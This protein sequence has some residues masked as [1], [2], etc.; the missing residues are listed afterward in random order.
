LEL[1]LVLVSF[2]CQP[3]S[4]SGQND[5][6]CGPPMVNKTLGGCPSGWVKLE[7]TCYFVNMYPYK[8]YAD[9]DNDCRD[10]FGLLMRI[11]SKV[12]FNAFSKLLDE[13]SYD[14]TEPFYTSGQLDPAVRFKFVWGGHSPDVAA[15]RTEIYD[16]W[17]DEIPREGD[18][19]PPESWGDRTFALLGNNGATWGFFLRNGTIPRPFICQAD[20][21]ALSAAIGSQR[22]FDYGV[23]GINNVRRSPCIQSE[24]AN[25]VYFEN[26]RAGSLATPPTAVFQCL[27]YGNPQPT[28]TWYRFGT[29]MQKT[30]IDPLTQTQYS[31][32]NG[33]LT[34]N[35]VESSR[36]SG[37]YACEAVNDLGAVMSRHAAL[38]F[39]ILPTFPKSSQETIERNA[40]QFA[41][42]E[43]KLSD[44]SNP[45]DLFNFQFFY[46]NIAPETS[47]DI[48]EV[49]PDF[50]SNLFV[51]QSTGRLYFS[52]VTSTDMGFYYCQ[53]GVTVGVS[54]QEKGPNIYLKV[55]NGGG[56]EISVMVA[57]GFPSNV[58]KSPLRGEDVQLECIGYGPIT[59]YNQ[60][61]IY[62]WRR[63]GLEIPSKSRW[64]DIF[65]RVLVIPNA[66][67]ED[68]GAY[69]CEI[70]DGNRRTSGYRRLQLT[71]NSGPYF[72]RRP[73]DLI[74]DEGTTQRFDCKASG[75]PPLTYAWFRGNNI[76][77]EL[78]DN[79]TDLDRARFT[80]DV[81]GSQ[82][83]LEIKNVKPSDSAAYG[84]RVTNS[85]ETIYGFAELRV[86]NFAPSFYKN[87]TSQESGLVGK[88]VY[89][90]CDVEGAPEPTRTW[91]FKGS[92]LA[93][94]K[95]MD[96]PDRKCPPTAKYCLLPSGK[97]QIQQLV[98]ADSGL[99]SCVAT[100][101]SGSANNSVS[102]AVAEQLT[103][104][105]APENRLVLVGSTVDLPC[106]L[107][108]TAANLDVNYMWKFENMEILFGRYDF[109]ARR[110]EL[111]QFY[112]P[113]KKDFGTLRISNIQYDYEG[114][115][116]CQ[117]QTPLG[118]E[119]RSAYL[120]VAG[121]PGPCAGVEV[122]S[123]N[124]TVFNIRWRSGTSHQSP[125]T[126]YQLELELA[127]NPGQWTVHSTVPMSEDIIVR[128]RSNEDT[129]LR[130]AQ[131]KGLPFY[132]Q[133][134]IR[135]SAINVYG[136]GLASPPSQVFVT[137][138][139][140]PS[141]A[142]QNITGG[143]GKVKTLV[144]RWKKI[145]L[146]YQ[147]GSN[148]TY[149]VQYRRVGDA[150]WLEASRIVGKP[151]HI[152]PDHVET[153][154]VLS[155][156][157]NE[158]SFKMFEARVRGASV[159][160]ETIN[161]V[162][163][164]TRLTGPWSDI[165]R[166]RSAEQVPVSAPINI[167]ITP[168]NA[169]AVDV[170]WEPPLNYDGIVGDILGYRIVYWPRIASACSVENN[171]YKVLLA[172]RQTTY[173]KATYGQVIGLEA[174]SFYCFSVQ[175]FNSAG[176]SPESSWRDVS[177][178]KMWPTDLP[179]N[180]V[181]HSTGEYSSISVTWN[182]VRQ[183]PNEESVD[184][185][186][187]R[188]W[189]TGAP[190]VNFTDV[191]AGLSNEVTVRYLSSETR[192]DLRVYA[193]S[194]GGIGTYS[195]PMIQFMLIP[196]DRCV[197]GASWEAPDVR[198]VFICSGAGLRA[199]LW[200]LALAGLARLLA[201]HY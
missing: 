123:I 29:N 88:S 184:G 14:K 93:V 166:L 151:M 64:G 112:R 53:V 111:T 40:F 1:L 137:V 108:A 140:P 16:F 173:G 26:T 85:Y 180:V 127:V 13:Q 74:V 161:N 9:A 3:L 61:L 132:Q 30:K 136:V 172:Q 189:V 47:S 2:L 42:I 46:S 72:V 197:P 12:E 52:E 199:S 89:L 103:F 109:D 44:N 133:Y 10:R 178:N 134:R 11:D 115:Y 142:P 168:F 162:E 191:D 90:P 32:T 195:S 4:I 56:D 157:T 149:D 129:G 147:G 23:V 84:C 91:R 125:I 82:P 158:I 68:S 27:A 6:Y 201:L 170:F 160:I 187:V 119:E 135:V 131:V 33:K 80:W 141:R 87:P 193:Y 24:P 31:V 152:P 7:S 183:Q 20:A 57:D 58:P 17:I 181:V 96:Q 106:Q 156:A 36:D 116:T 21:T 50:R 62:R 164:K 174:D 150:D 121:P 126:A 169:T 51:S 196:K 49:R 163:T 138:S 60:P 73:Y 39:G 107:K 5:Y 86:L 77:T 65:K 153:A 75:T 100:N 128:E 79:I 185:Y 95:V 67:M 167:R 179:T 78:L 143:G 19:K 175:L 155:G 192:Y 63:V 15:W 59:R 45:R 69:E 25:E 159:K 97:L 22:G 198:Y 105:F 114:N 83:Y 34:I 71:I 41:N 55:N 98:A 48:R 148:F 200:A 118:Y 8:T 70:E 120:R 188:Y 171:K 104:D 177:T 145:P 99:Y 117:A 37:N 92:D 102:L 144:V 18:G 186:M 139:G 54:T 130:Q 66:Q 101:P 154:I 165:I 43:C 194:S 38:K 28:Y 146:A 81:S 35:Q 122:P 110:Y 94:I 76:K 182:G 176:D 190:A 113:Y 124:S